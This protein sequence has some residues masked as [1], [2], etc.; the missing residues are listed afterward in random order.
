MGFAPSRHQAQSRTPDSKKPL[1]RTERL[2][3]EAEKAD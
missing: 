1:R 3:V 2:F